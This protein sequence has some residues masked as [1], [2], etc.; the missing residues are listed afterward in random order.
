MKSA[1][2]THGDLSIRIGFETITPEM[3]KQYMLNRRLTRTLK[4]NKAISYGA[5]MKNNHWCLSHQGVAF[6][7]SDRMTDGATRMTACIA[8]GVPFVTLVSRGWPCDVIDKIDRCTAR[9]MRDALS[10]RRGEFVPG[11]FTSVVTNMMLSDGIEAP[12]TKYASATLFPDS[13]IEAF[14]QRYSAGIQFSLD[15]FKSNEANICTAPVR[16]AVAKAYYLGETER[17]E[18]FCQ[19]LKTGES[20][21]AHSTDDNAAIRL[22]NYL[23]GG[24]FDRSGGQRGVI[25][26]RVA[27]CLSKFLNREP[28]K[29]KTPLVAKCDPFP[30][31]VSSKKFTN[32]DQSVAESVRAAIA[33]MPD[34]V[35]A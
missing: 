28:M 7:V 19:V 22:R 26:L 35:M 13:A 2:I 21:S 25:Y 15:Q 12:G 1:T 9:S 34:P 31:P 29:Q 14:A 18:E 10:S 17:L 16:T 11:T 32:L 3:A 20:V 23:I 30:L 6:D 8:V 4:Q 33:A 5:S 27:F 24:K